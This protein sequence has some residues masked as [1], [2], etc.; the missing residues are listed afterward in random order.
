MTRARSTRT[1]PPRTLHS[2]SSLVPRSTWLALLLSVLARSVQ[3]TR[4]HTAWHNAW[5]RFELTPSAVSHGV[6]PSQGVKLRD[7][8]ITR[9]FFTVGN[10]IETECSHPSLTCNYAS[11]E[12]SRPCWS[13]RRHSKACSKVRGQTSV[14]HDCV[15]THS[16]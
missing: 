3:G 8:F 7:F 9:L 6:R 15:Q 5:L 2:G 1:S 11:K 13:T 14:V 12:G 10:C 4:T 16:I